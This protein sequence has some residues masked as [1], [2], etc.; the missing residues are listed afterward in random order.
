[1]LPTSKLQGERRKEA[2]KNKI[3]KIGLELQ[4]PQSELT[5][6]SHTKYTHTWFIS[7]NNSQAG[8]EKN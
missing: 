2:F 6:S 3:M 1:M 5:P 8:V 4:F 7:H